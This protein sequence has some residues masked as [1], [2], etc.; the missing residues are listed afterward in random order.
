[1]KM[2]FLSIN[3]NK[4]EMQL[5]SSPKDL[6]Y[7]INILRLKSTVYRIP[8]WVENL[9]RNKHLKDCVISW[10]RTLDVHALAWPIQ[11]VKPT[12]KTWRRNSLNIFLSHE[13]HFATP[14]MTCDGNSHAPFKTKWVHT[15]CIYLAVRFTRSIRL[16]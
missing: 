12:F 11:R 4:P 3:C 7:D 1:M 10:S 13:L 15:R 8:N 16:G 2:S 9:L 5:S 14:Q 6:Y